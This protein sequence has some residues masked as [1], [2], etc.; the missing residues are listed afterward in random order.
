[1]AVEDGRGFAAATL[2]SLRSQRNE[3]QRQR[4]G[5]KATTTSRESRTAVVFALKSGDQG[6]VEERSI[7]ADLAIRGSNNVKINPPT[8][9]EYVYTFTFPRPL[10]HTLYRRSIIKRR[11]KT[12]VDIYMNARDCP[13]NEN[14]AVSPADI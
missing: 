10:Q 7:R 9:I 4:R 6:I 8:N 1:M 3:R 14:L 12:L 11:C 5:V 2:V 13:N